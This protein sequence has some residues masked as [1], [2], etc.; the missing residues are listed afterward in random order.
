MIC[1]AFFP[2]LR[3]SLVVSR[4][5][6]KKQKLSS[7]HCGGHSKLRK[8]PSPFSRLSSPHCGGHSG[9]SEEIVA[10]LW[11][12]SPHSGGHSADAK[13]IRQDAK[14]SSPHSGGHSCR[15]ASSNF[16]K[17]FLPRIAGVTLV[18]SPIL[19][20]GFAFFPA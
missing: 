6:N 1:Q 18:F 7:P 4:D 9:S 13:Q 19:A 2:A 10:R 3:G 14:L 20:N 12:S 11:L 15:Y 8:S 5:R 16:F 17:Y